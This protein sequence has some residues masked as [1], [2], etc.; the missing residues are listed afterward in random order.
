MPAGPELQTNIRELGDAQE[1][2][3]EDDI[4]ISAKSLSHPHLTNHA[5][6]VW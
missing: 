3:E 6:H 5:L 2:A 1:R 4:I